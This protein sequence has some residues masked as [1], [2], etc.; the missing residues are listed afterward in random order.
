MKTEIL[1]GSLPAI[2]LGEVNV[3]FSE[4]FFLQAIRQRVMEY[5]MLSSGF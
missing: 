2:L 5:H 4:I 3:T 1:G